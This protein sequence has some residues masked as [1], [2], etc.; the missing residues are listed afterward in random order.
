MSM[1]DKIRGMFLGVAIGDALGLPAESKT[2]EYIEE[3]FGRITDYI[4][5]R[6]KEGGD[7][8]DDT[9]L[10]IA[11]AE[12]IVE[13]DGELNMDLIAAHHVIAFKE[14]T[15]GWGWTT[16]Q[17]IEKIAK[18]MSWKDSGDFGND[19]KKGW[20][21]GI[22]MKIAPIGAAMYFRGMLGEYFDLIPLYAAMTHRTSMGVSSGFAHAVAISHCLSTNEFDFNI[23]G[24]CADI[25]A[26]SL[27]GRA[28][29]KSTQNEDDI[30]QIFAEMN[31]SVGLDV[32]ELRALYGNGTCYVYN[33]LPFTY[34]MFMRNANSIECLYDTVNAGGDADTNGSMVGA[35]LGALN[36]TSIFP[37]HLVTGLKSRAEIVDLADRF[38]AVFQK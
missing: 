5:A 3:K 35:L 19:E 23:S 33:S 24:F 31:K 12:A 16:K 7:Y 22:P 18:G 37:K 29:F 8:T 11:T 38:Y 21:N 6:G 17:A 27:N 15:A 1:K 30:C 14:S 9:Q 36:G 26:A 4:A 20:G 32:N 25:H 28:Y 13:A 2:P 34:S 10:T